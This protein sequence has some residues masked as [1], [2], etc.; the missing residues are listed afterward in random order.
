MFFTPTNKIEITELFKGIVAVSPG[1]QYKVGFYA[2]LRQ[3]STQDP[4]IEYAKSFYGKGGIY[5][6]I[7]A[8]GFTPNHYQEELIQAYEDKEPRIACRAGKGPGKSKITAAVLSHW[9][10][11]NPDSA[12][13]VTAPTF[14]QCQGVWLNEVKIL[15]N[16]SAA[17]PRL[18]ALFNITGKGFG[19]LGAKPTEWGCQLITA[20]TKE[21]FQG[22]HRKRIAFLEEEA[23]GVKPEISQAITETIT[24]AKGH[25]LHIRIGNPNSRSCK[26]FDSFNSDSKNWKGM[27]WNTEHMEETSYFSKDQN[28]KVAEEFGKDSDIY[29]ISVLG[30]FP[31]IDPD[32]L[33][34]EED[35]VACCTEEALRNAYQNNPDTTKQIGIDLAR[36]GGDECVVITRQGG[37][38][39]DMWARKTDP[40]NAVNKAIQL[41]D[42]YGWNS[43]DCMF[44]VD[45]SGM[46][47]SVVGVLGG[48]LY[49]NRRV[50]EFYSQN[51]AYHSDKYCDK[52]TEAWMLFNKL[53]K[54]KQV[55]LGEKLDE[56]LRKQL[57]TRRYIVDRVS[58]RLKIESKDDYKKNNKDSE[59]EE[60]GKSPDRADALMMAFYKYATE[61]SRIAIGR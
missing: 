51:S 48:D 59:H 17:D 50:H 5:R 31:N 60:I 28:K 57:T 13:I 61:S 36:Y 15:V 9:V 18:S 41:Q 42:Q 46:G 11:T 29:R 4:L 44:V 25:F 6:Y 22:L 26:F 35:L 47:E 1:S 39:L 53:L 45:T 56:R 21:A 54:K 37:I 14:R 32:C 10:L 19:I 43:E 24:N 38:L 49:M 34:A 52:I 40:N 27:V 16:N 3:A 8:T 2:S 23:S 20:T 30:E 7:E 55:Y 12:L 58:G 33:I